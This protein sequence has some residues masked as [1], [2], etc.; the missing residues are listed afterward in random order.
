MSIYL[1]NAATTKVKKE[2]LKTINDYL[3]HDWY[4]PSA[5]YKPAQEIKGKLKWAK[6]MI[7]ATIGANENQIYFTSSGSEANSWVIQGFKKKYPNAQ[8]ITTPIEHKSILETYESVCMKHNYLNIDK[9]TGQVNIEELERYL[10]ELHYHRI[11][12]LVSVQ[13]VNNET[14]IIQDIEKISEIVHK[15]GAYLHTDAVQAYSH[16][17][18]NVRK[19]GID[20][21]SV[22]GHKFGCPKG[23][24]FLYIKEYKSIDPLIYGTQER[25]MRG[26]TENIPYIM[27]MEKA[28]E[29]NLN[30]LDHYDYIRKNNIINGIY[31]KYNLEKLGCTI[32]F[33]NN[34]HKLNNVIS[35]TL[36]KGNVAEYVIRML[37]MKE[38]YVSAGSAC[39]SMSNKPSY[40]LKKMGLTD[41]EI[42][43]TIRISFSDG[44][45][46]EHIDIVIGALKSII[47]K[48]DDTNDKENKRTIS[49]TKELH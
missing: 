32:N 27:G 42:M 1:D 30:L 14:G 46:K 47:V 33:K 44:L 16:I 11:P 40:V 4:N 41:E 26:G 45:T 6:L 13:W 31:F 7:G 35:C 34:Y 29:L 24:G 36:P 28:A 18:I 22:S 39:N 3:V 12:T 37:S 43:R 9:T 15:Y 21:M 23:I 38:I 49:S 10:D 19:I 17:P 25:G 8:I 2:V 20:F 5:L 48:G